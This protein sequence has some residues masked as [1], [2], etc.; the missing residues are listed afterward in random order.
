[1]FDA[2]EA[3]ANVMCAAIFFGIIFIGKFFGGSLWGLMPLS[4]CIASG[5]YLWCRELIQQGRNVEWSSEKERGETA[6]VN[7]V[8]E[9]VELIPPWLAILSRGYD[10]SAQLEPE[11]TFQNLPDLF[12]M[13]L[14]FLESPSHNI[15]ISAS[16][17]LVSFLANC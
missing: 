13:V 4:V 10:V 17:C 6:T 5:V 14:A 16:E 15:R 11:D 7:L 8:P 9:S 2:L 12:T 3:R 1:M